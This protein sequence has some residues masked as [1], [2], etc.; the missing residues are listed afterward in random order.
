[1]PP[2]HP[3]PGHFGTPE[4]LTEHGRIP[5][6]KSGRRSEN[7]PADRR[8]H[9]PRHPARHRPKPAGEFIALT[10]GDLSTFGSADHL[11]ASRDPRHF[12]V[13]EGRAPLLSVTEPRGAKPKAKP[14]M[15]Y[16]PRGQ[17]RWLS[18]KDQPRRGGRPCRG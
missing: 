10:G 14:G 4:P 9:R 3:P 2:S 13:V 6:A 16:T 12:E 11:A 17:K 8:G 15:V 1:M 7:G 5:G 18:T